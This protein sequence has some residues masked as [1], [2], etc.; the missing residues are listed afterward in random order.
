M[1]LCKEFLCVSSLLDLDLSFYRKCSWIY[2]SP[3][4]SIYLDK[5]ANNNNKLFAF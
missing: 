4:R 2:E 5:E 1:A 3:Q